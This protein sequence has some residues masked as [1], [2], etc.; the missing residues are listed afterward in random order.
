MNTTSNNKIPLLN[1]LLIFLTAMYTPCIRYFL[2]EAVGAADQAAW[3]SYLASLIVFIPLLYVLCRVMQ[4]FEGQS[5]ATIMCRVFGKFA[6]KAV[7][8][9]LMLWLF[10]LLSLYIK[11]S[12]ETLVTT[13]YVGTDIR[14]IMFLAVALTALFLR[15]GLPVI[16]RM[17]TIIFAVA[18]LQYVIILVL[19]FI[20]F[21]PRNVTPISTEDVG[22][23]INST[24][25][26]LTLSVYITFIFIFNDQI[27]FG[28][29]YTG[30]FVFAAT[31]LTSA[32]TGT[33]LAVLGIFG[34][35]LINKLK[36]PF[37]SAVENIAVLSGNTGIESLF[38]SIWMMIESMLILIFAYMVIRLLREICG[39]KRQVPLLTAVM[40][41]A[42]A[43]AIY[44][45]SDVFELLDFS[46][47]VV[48]W[49][50]LTFGLGIPFALF[51]VA[52]ARKM[53]PPRPK[54]QRKQRAKQP[55]VQT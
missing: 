23:V 32:N 50:N 49:F 40:G 36:F 46:K 15:F 51:I 48:P 5:L 28:N 9:A 11:Y 6:G 37:H 10:V 7:A 42:Y 19:L 35:N 17:N 30:K 38:I 41:L 22:P 21:D 13:V 1:A 39:L 26:P 31:F 53:L 25:Y 8:I 18:V 43:F 12:G 27:R 33:V 54:R 45:C 16:S 52:K 4:A 29:R 55:A 24:I 14:F 44:L 3:L 2:N 34:A 20:N 47:Y